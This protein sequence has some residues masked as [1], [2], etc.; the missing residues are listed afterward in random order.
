MDTTLEPGRGPAPRRLGVV[1]PPKN[2]IFGGVSIT[3]LF[4]PWVCGWG[5]S[6]GG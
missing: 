1:W 4:F 5:P 3:P 2:T 6:L